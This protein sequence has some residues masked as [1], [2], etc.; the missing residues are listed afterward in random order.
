MKNMT[1]MCELA[2][3]VL[4]DEIIKN[5]ITITQK[6][7]PVRD[8]LFVIESNL[9]SPIIKA[10]FNAY[11]TLEEPLKNPRLC[12]KKKVN[13]YELI[14]YKEIPPYRD[15]I[16]TVHSEIQFII[17]LLYSILPQWAVDNFVTVDFK[18]NTVRI[19]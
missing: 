11:V 9:E 8:N 12:N 7:K 14:L 2:E 1:L 18:T 3:K 15:L 5:W 19:K 6:I 4:V 17:H 13:F 16:L 10:Q